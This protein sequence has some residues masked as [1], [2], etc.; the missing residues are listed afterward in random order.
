MG[1]FLKTHQEILGWIAL[2][3]FLLFIAMLIAV[4]LIIVRLPKSYLFMEEPRTAVLP[5]L[6][7]WPYLIF[8]NIAGVVLVVGGLAM[9]VLP[10][11]GLL[12]LAVGLSFMS[13]PG[14]HRLIR[15]VAGRPRVLRMINWLR[16]KAGRPPLENSDR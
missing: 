1:T 7:R 6:V 2:A 16:L 8:K 12:T 10:G 3:S 14:K 4:P 11:Q 5:P 15:K 13:I 9:L